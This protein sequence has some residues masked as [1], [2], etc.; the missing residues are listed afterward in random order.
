[1]SETPIE[2]RSTLTYPACDV[3]TAEAMPTDAC[4]ISTTAR[5][6]GRS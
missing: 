5:P 1:M 6:A 4:Q 3:S 2:V